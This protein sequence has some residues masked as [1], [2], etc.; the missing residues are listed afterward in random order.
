VGDYDPRTV[1]DVTALPQLEFDRQA[2]PGNSIALAP[3]LF[4]PFRALSDIP[5]KGR[6][7]LFGAM[8]WGNAYDPTLE[9]YDPR[10]ALDNHPANMSLFNFICA[11]TVGFNRLDASACALTVF[12]SSKQP[13]GA[14]AGN[15]R[16]S[17]LIGNFLGGNGKFTGF[18]GTQPSDKIL[19][20]GS[21]L[22]NGMG[23]P[24]VQIDI[25]LAAADRDG[26]VKLCGLN[27]G[28]GKDAFRTTDVRRHWADRLV[29]NPDLND[30]ENIA[31]PWI[32][33]REGE[34]YNCL[35]PNPVQNAAKGLVLCGG[36]AMGA[37]PGPAAQ[38]LAD[39][40]AGA[41]RNSFNV[42][43]A[44][45]RGLSPEQEALLGCGPYFGGSPARSSNR[46]WEA[47][48]WGFRSRISA[49]APWFP[50]VSAIA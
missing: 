24:L 33:S 27:R 50:R 19:S 5:F 21:S 34:S 14:D 45:D 30:P 29:N 9:E 32:Y 18:L 4:D 11:T 28:C 41:P 25:D 43:F 49:L 39:R 48:R 20:Y 16:I 3:V 38:S 8:W 40:L 1:G 12:S 26:G 13:S 22:P 7:N 2:N 31:Y 10:N 47:I 42:S 15:P 46:L 35:G 6:S 37:F 17:S 36:L 44:L 23:I